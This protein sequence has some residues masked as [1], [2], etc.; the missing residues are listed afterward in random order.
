MTIKL[1]PLVH[2]EIVVHDADAAYELL[3]RVFGATKVEE[4]F[5]DQLQN[6][7]G[8]VRIIHVELGGTI[9]Q[10]IEPSDYGSWA[11]QLKSSGPGVHNITY[12][13]D[14]ISHAIKALADEG[15]KTQ[16][17]LPIDLKLLLGADT[18]APAE[19]N[20]CMIDTRDKLGFRLEL[21]HKPS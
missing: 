18:P 5:A 2:I 20:A 10:L 9:L 4:P 19:P 3:Q 21:F 7:G 1:S 14:H 8:L 17:Q 6:M 11:E 15:C 16:S 13:V 12:Q